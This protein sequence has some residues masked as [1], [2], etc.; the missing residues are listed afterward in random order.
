MTDNLSGRQHVLPSRTHN[1]SI[2]EFQQLKKLE[3]VSRNEHEL[4]FG[5]HKFILL[6]Y[7]LTSAGVD[8]LFDETGL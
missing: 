4:R 7:S 3:F 8:F 1:A 5:K 2:E 6:Y